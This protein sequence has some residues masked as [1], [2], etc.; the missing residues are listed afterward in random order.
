MDRNTF[1]YQHQYKNYELIRDSYSIKDSCVNDTTF[2]SLG[3]PMWTSFTV[4]F[5]PMHKSFF[6]FHMYMFFVPYVYVFFSMCIC[7][8]IPISQYFVLDVER[9][10][11][12]LLTGC[13]NILS[14][15]TANIHVNVL[16]VQHLT[17]ET[18]GQYVHIRV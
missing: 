12:I 4:I 1:A 8:F 17:G 9:F 6:D 16:L 7:F 10:H 5:I 14:A 13:L 15:P 2:S 18:E 11:S 3:Y